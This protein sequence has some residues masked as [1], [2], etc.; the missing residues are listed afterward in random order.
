MTESISMSDPLRPA[1]TPETSAAAEPSRSVAEQLRLALEAGEMG[2]WEWRVAEGR[3]IWSEALE[4]MHGLEP[5]SFGGTFDDYKRDVHP[6]D[7]QGVF[8][9]VT[10]TMAGE[11]HRLRYRIIR[12]DGTVRWLEARG[13]LFRDENGLPQS[14]VGICTDITDRRHAAASIQLLAEAGSAF[15]ASL[16][17]DATIA[18]VTQL[19]LPALADYCIF[20]VVEGSTVRRVAAAHADLQAQ[21]MMHELQQFAPDLQRPGLVANAI[22]TGEALLVPDWSA[23]E[24]SWSPASDQHQSV[25]Q[26]LHPRS[27]IVVPLRSSAGDVLG[28]LTLVLSVQ[29]RHYDGA[30]LE[31]AR[32]L[33]ARAASAMENARLYRAVTEA[34]R[35]LQLQAHALETQTQQMQDQAAAMETQQVEMEQQAEELQAVNEELHQTNHELDAARESAVSAQEYVTGILGAITDPFVVYDGEWRFQFLNDAAMHVFSAAG[36]DSRASILGHVVWELYPEILGTRFEGEMRRASDE[37][38]PVLFEEF[39]PVRAEWSE[40][41]CYPLPQRGVAVIWKDITEKKRAEERL[42]F[43]SRASAILSSSLDYRTTVSQVAQLLVPQLADWCGIQLLDERGE[44]RQLAVAHTDPE[45]VKWAW[46]LDKRYPVDMD[47]PVGV[48]NVL[49]TQKS[50]LYSEIADEMLVAGAVDDEHLAILRELGMASVLIVPLLS[51][52]G[53]IGVISLIAAESGR[54]YGAA[55]QALVEELAERAGLAI[56]NSR[57]YTATADAR[58]AIEL[59]RAQLEQV[60]AEMRRTNDDLTE[61]TQLAEEARRAAEEANRVKSDFLAHMSHELRTPLN[62][63]AGYADLMQLGIH[64]ELTPHQSEDLERIKRAQRLLLGHINDVL[65]FAKVDAGHIHYE[66]RPFALRSVVSQLDILVEPQMAARSLQYDGGDIPE[67]IMVCADEEKVRQ[68]LVNLLSNATKFTPPGGRISIRVA[69]SEHTVRVDV[70]D[71][72]MG[73]PADKLDTIFD[74]FVQ[75][76]RTLSSSHQGTGLGLAISRDL[77]RGMAGQLTVTSTDGEGSTFSLVLPAWPMA[78]ATEHA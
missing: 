44:L 59:S 78:S 33:G 18:A 23:V 62:A 12:P 58:A 71:T 66:I 5:G 22:R 2:T 43:L 31:L 4:R 3:V 57:L 32:A 50:E 41:R 35:Q 13:T 55:D 15:H 47:A 37:R 68:I 64:G 42:H 9:A 40:V 61:K 8:D 73:I 26:R 49:R 7:L 28:A 45:K 74:P 21:G 39:H 25:V 77:A 46:E 53:V 19:A 76:E 38:I 69:S 72:G 16:D 1:R 36:A 30:D 56:D 20:D 48:P 51:R 29:E 75:L 63:I 60:V 14:L 11:E 34:G 52:S 27:L 54:R 70:T 67:S 17:Y 65:N 6:E 10:R 24:S